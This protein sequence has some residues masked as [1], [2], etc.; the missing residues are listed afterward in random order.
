M[1]KAIVIGSPGAGKS[2]F[3]RKLKNITDL[4]LYYLDMIWHKPDQTNISK[5][6]FDQ[7][8]NKIIKKDS[9]IIDGNYLRTMEQRLKACDTVFFLDYPLEVCLEGVNARIGKQREDMPWIESQ[10]DQEFKQWIIEFPQ[11]QLPEIY[12]LLENYKKDKEIII[13]KSRKE[14]DEYLK[15][16]Y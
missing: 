2:T 15:K 11:V 6:E 9:W 14:A 4:E 13:F 16:L 7:Q 3:S 10:F 12:K 5:E 8:L 1:L